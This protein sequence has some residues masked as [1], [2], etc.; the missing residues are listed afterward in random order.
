MALFMASCDN[1]WDPDKLLSSDGDVMFSSMNVDIDNSIKETLPETGLDVNDYTVYLT[2]TATDAACGS[3]KYGELPE[4]LALPVGDYRI[5]IENAPLQDAAWDSPFYHAA[6]SFSIKENEICSLGAMTCVL[7]N[8]AVSVRYSEALKAALGDDVKVTVTVA[9]NASLDF[10]ADET[11]IGYFAMP[12]G[13]STLVASFSGTVNGHQTTLIKTFTGIEIGQHHYVTFSVNNG[14]I[15]PSLIIDADIT[16]DDVDID[17][18]GGEDP[19]PGDRPGEDGTPAITSMTLD[20]DGVNTVTDDLIARVDIVAPNGIANLEVTIVSESLT[21]E[22]L[23]GVG[24]TDHFD[25]AHPGEFDEALKGLGFQTGDDVIGKETLTFDIS[26]FMP[27]L[28]F[29]PGNHSFRL[30]VTD[31]KG[32]NVSATLKFYTP[33]Q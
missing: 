3:W 21:P 17:I 5:D 24:L 32:L 11:R 18:P 10:Y 29:F 9:E 27:L 8:V 6:K 26:S 33:Q 15:D 20:L 22:E 4:V 1:D 12:G 13:A 19:D 25:L 30:D 14:S 2:N 23:A 16:F 28:A 31:T 7:S